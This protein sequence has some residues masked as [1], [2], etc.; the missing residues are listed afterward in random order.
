MLRKRP[1]IQTTVYIVVYS[2]WPKDITYVTYRR[3]VV[4]GV[5]LSIRYLQV[6]IDGPSQLWPLVTID[7]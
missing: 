3:G 5:I 7:S 2:Q 1:K 6:T 4:F